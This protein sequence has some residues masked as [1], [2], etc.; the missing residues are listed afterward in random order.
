MVTPRTLAPVAV[1][2]VFVA[3]LVVW[4]KPDSPEKQVR[5]RFHDLKVDFPGE[6]RALVLLSATLQGRLNGGDHAND[7]QELECE[8]V[9]VDGEWRFRSIRIVQ[10]LKP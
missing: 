5:N 3:I 8:L 1:V 7:A 10:V 9:H 2:A 6:S 4:L